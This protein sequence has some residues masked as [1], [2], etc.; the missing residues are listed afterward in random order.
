MGS[1]QEHRACADKLADGWDPDQE[2]IDA[3]RTPEGLLSLDNTRV[4]VSQ[5]FG[6]ARI[7]VR[8]RGAGELLPKSFPTRRFRFFSGKARRLGLPPPK[9]W[10]GLV[11]HSNNGQQVAAN[12]NIKTP[13]V[14]QGIRMLVYFWFGYHGIEAWEQARID[15]GFDCESTGVLRIV[16][17]NERAALDWGIT[18]ARWYTARLHSGESDYSWLESDYAVWTSTEAQEAELD[19]EPIKIEVGEYP[20]FKHLRRWLRD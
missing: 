10:G 19:C 6:F 17:D 3:I 1:L 4:A 7:T 16:S 15:P 2:P 14:A 18:V 20:S 12:R 8:I 9:T 13:T 5:E 11:S